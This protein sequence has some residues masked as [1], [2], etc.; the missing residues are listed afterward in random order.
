MGA[1]RL[2][3]VKFWLYCAVVAC[4][5]GAMVPFWFIGVD[6]LVRHA[7]M[8]RDSATKLMIIPECTMAITT[9]LTALTMDA[10]APSVARLTALSMSAMAVLILSYSCMMVAP[11][12]YPTGVLILLSIGFAVAQQFFFGIVFHAEANTIPLRVTSLASGILGCASNLLAAAVP[13]TLTGNEDANLAKLTA[14]AALSLPIYAGTLLSP[15]TRTS[16][17]SPSDHSD[18]LEVPLASPLLLKHA[19]PRWPS[20]PTRFRTPLAGESSPSLIATVIRAAGEGES[21][22]ALVATVFRGR[23]ESCDEVEE[24]LDFQLD[25]LSEETTPK[26]PSDVRL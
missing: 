11:T 4:L 2:L 18:Q 1:M 8:D 19:S 16:R 22:P 24:D 23:F 5:Y 26:L 6:V 15:A 20:S 3:P 21:S 13:F 7:G 10:F 25:G 14:V 17:E 9:P 12:W